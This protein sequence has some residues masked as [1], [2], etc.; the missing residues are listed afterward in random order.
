MD[1]PRRRANARVTFDGVDDDPDSGK[2]NNK[3]ASKHEA[4]GERMYSV[5]GRSDI[6]NANMPLVIVAK[7]FSS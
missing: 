1:S 7:A 5:P 2:S 6:T 4:K 3:R